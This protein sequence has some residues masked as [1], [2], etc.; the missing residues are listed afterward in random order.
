MGVEGTLV[1]VRTRGELLHREGAERIE[2]PVAPGRPL[3]GLGDHHGLQHQALD[4]I[5]H[6]RLP[7]DAP[8]RIQVERP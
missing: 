6:I 7:R 4:E 1:L 2:Q 5:S 8:D 3:I